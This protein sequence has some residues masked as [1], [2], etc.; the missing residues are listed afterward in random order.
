MSVKGLYVSLL[1]IL[2]Q[3]VLIPPHWH[4]DEF[5][6][7]VHDQLDL[8]EGDEI[9]SAQFLKY[10]EEYMEDNWLL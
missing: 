2:H 5:R 3:A 8:L 9:D 6:T 1:N 4:M 7:F 10:L